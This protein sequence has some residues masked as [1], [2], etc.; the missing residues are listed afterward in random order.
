MRLNSK[1]FSLKE[2]EVNSRD[3]G[4]MKFACFAC[5]YPFYARYKIP[6]KVLTHLMQEI[7]ARL[8]RRIPAGTQ[9]R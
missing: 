9:A 1:P 4:K 3:L 2:A 7:V 8:P 5:I 6:Q